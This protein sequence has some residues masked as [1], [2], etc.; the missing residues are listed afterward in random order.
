MVA[1]K[2]CD[3][4]YYQDDKNIEA[5]YNMSKKHAGTSVHVHLCE[6]HK[7]HF[8]AMTMDQMSASILEGMEAKLRRIHPEVK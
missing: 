8:D 5:V 6:A 7:N 3:V 2:L 4:C 1:V